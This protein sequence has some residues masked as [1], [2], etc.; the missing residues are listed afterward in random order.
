MGLEGFDACRFEQPVA[1]HG[2]LSIGGEQL[3]FR[4]EAI[5]GVEIDLSH[6]PV[7]PRRTI[8]RRALIRLHPEGGGASVL[9]WC[10]F[11]YAT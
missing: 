10:E 9:G 6:T 3:G 11:N 7:P 2:E 8:Y 5:S 4:L 1:L